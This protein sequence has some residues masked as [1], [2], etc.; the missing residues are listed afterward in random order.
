LD[1]SELQ[2][3]G[4]V[5]TPALRCILCSGATDWEQRDGPRMQRGDG[6]K[7]A[8]GRQAWTSGAVS[9]AAG[10]TESPDQIKRGASKGVA[11][12]ARVQQL[13]EDP[14]KGRVPGDSTE[15]TKPEGR[16]PHQARANH[17]SG[18]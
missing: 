13:T 17:S 18:T 15:Q 3:R 6:K 2:R 7:S 11:M 10:R 12:P 5:L 8:L 4:A 1:K 9:T 16:R 14:R